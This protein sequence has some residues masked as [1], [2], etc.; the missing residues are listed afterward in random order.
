MSRKRFAQDESLEGEV[1]DLSADGRGVVRHPDGKTVF[2]SDA[3]TGELVRYRRR[4]RQRR[5]DE[6]ELLEVLR[7][8][9]DRVEP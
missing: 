3:L 1:V 4:K 2:V 8:S 9:P 5:F 7:P 6:A